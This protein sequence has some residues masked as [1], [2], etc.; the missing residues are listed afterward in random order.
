MLSPYY[1]PLCGQQGT[2]LVLGAICEGCRIKARSARHDAPKEE[3][4]FG[5]CFY[6]RNETM[7][8]ID[9]VI[10]IIRGGPANASW[11][12]VRACKPCN[13]KK[14]DRLPSE[15]CPENEVAL[16]IER[17]MTGHILPRMRNEKVLG[18]PYELLVRVRTICTTFTRSLRFEINGLDKKRFDR[19][20]RA[21]LAVDKLERYVVDMISAAEDKILNT[22]ADAGMARKEVRRKSHEWV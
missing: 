20:W 18:D 4:V 5:T 15:W 9:H 19:A 6:C 13:S 1:C 21:F 22:E 8:G 12:L 2:V 10:P 17:C 16:S 7:L 3:M 14:N 11:N